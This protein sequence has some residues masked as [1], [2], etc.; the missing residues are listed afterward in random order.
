MEEK[1][2]KPEAKAKAAPQEGETPGAGAQTEEPVP[3]ADI[4]AEKP[5]GEASETQP[6]R[7]RPAGETPP[8]ENDGP[9]ESGPPPAE[10][11]TEETPPEAAAEE[12]PEEAPAEADED[13]GDNED[14]EDE[15]LSEEE[16]RRLADMTRTVQVSIEQI[17]A[18]A[19]EQEAARAAAE[20]P[21]AETA[22][23]EEEDETET[24]G[25][26]FGAG[27]LRLAKWFMLVVFLVLVIA[28]AGIAWLYRGA[29]PD[30]LPQI[31][32]SFGGQELP[33]TDYDWK[34]P[35]VGRVIQRTYADTLYAEDYRLPETLGSLRPE[36]TVHPDG[37][38]TT[39]T[40]WD[41]EGE[42][43]Y[44]GSAAG[45]MAAGLPGSGDY[46]ARLVVSQPQ[47][48][49][50]DAAAVSGTQSYRFGFSV[51]IAPS[52]RL[53]SRTAD[54]GGIAALR[55]TNV[56]E[57][58][59]PTLQSEFE[60]AGFV[61][62]NGAWLL[63]LPIPRDARPGDYELRVQAGSYS[64]TLAL[65]VR[66]VEW[67]QKDV[68]SRSRLTTP[69]LAPE[70]TPPEVQK[71]LAVTG[72]KIRWPGAGFVQPFL[73]SVTVT[74]PYGAT[75]YVG[76][77]ASQ[78]ADGAGSGRTASNAVVAT[79]K[80]DELIAPADGEVLLAEDLGG[81]AG[82][83][84]VI[85]HGAGLKSI[86]YGLASLQVEAGDTVVRGQ[87]LGKTGSAVIA[88]A[89]IGTVPVE[90]LSIWRG[91]CDALKIY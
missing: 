88:E 55:V 32:A 42:A 47:S 85:E 80:G 7:E 14:D 49:F 65:T 89:R 48:R 16:R 82:N 46:R 19:A 73:R 11:E 4:E 58:E 81:A 40:V 3:A 62:N 29:T 25:Q 84:V 78:I 50:G 34:V 90:P 22:A 83:T 1:E 8:E 70:D 57:G 63:Y 44:E 37:M 9:G 39:L 5:A 51:D 17:M 76:R 24:L 72:E 12:A 74:L 21:A 61:Q 86:F 77:S 23:A 79:K 6:E 64:E 68:S 87:P 67:V 66:G 41:A 75:E 20:P 35:V 43:V 91:Q 45:L 13:D 38:E 30:A 54:Q 36:V 10:E 27:V 52:V 18:R 71:L 53:G 15:P 56:P 28:G 31:A 59:T 26:R 60:D 69:Y 33:A 2:R